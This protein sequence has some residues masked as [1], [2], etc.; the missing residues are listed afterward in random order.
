MRRGKTTEP[1][2]LRHEG[3]ASSVEYAVLLGL[4]AVSVTAGVV[5]LGSRMPGGM[6]VSTGQSAQTSGTSG[7]GSTGAAASAAANSPLFSDKFNSASDTKNK[8]SFE[9]SAWT[10]Q[11]SA[12]WAGQNGP[13]TDE[14]RALANM[15]STATDYVVSVDAK[16]TAGNGYGVFF[17]V[18][19][20]AATLDGYS[21]QYDPGYGGGQFIMRK[22]VNGYEMWPPFAAVAAPAGFNWDNANRHME[23]TVQGS[24]FTARIDGQTVLVGSDRTYAM[25]GTG[26]R[27]WAGGQVRFNNFTVNPIGRAAQ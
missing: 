11:N 9:G 16:L 18:T 24:T 8:W 21:F 25:G 14:N 19:G 13:T 27:V 6:N 2:L 4:V 15:D 1:G 23:V 20:D 5:T 7:A 10:I 26:L 12:L 17:R 3:G 22:F